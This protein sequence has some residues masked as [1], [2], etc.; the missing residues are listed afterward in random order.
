MTPSAPMPPASRPVD[1]P[2]RCACG[3]L[4][5][6]AL[7][8]G[9]SMGTR[10]LCYC[11]D[12]QAFARFLGGPGILDH[13]GGTD[14]FQIA[15]ARV[16][17]SEAGALSCMRLSA[18]GMFRFYCGQCRTPVGN[19]VGPR[20]PL[21]SLHLPFLE[22]DGNVTLRDEWLGPPLGAVQTKF[23]VGELPA[24]NAH[25]VRVVAKV[26]SRLGT[27]WLTGAGSPSPFFDAKTRAPRVEPRV[28]S[29]QERADLRA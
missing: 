27:W 10:M 24:R 17:L 29:A 22:P 11:D 9:P 5:G 3:A 19:C 25:A 18:K 13:W 16:R 14:V 6:E 23:A 21:I 26:L 2:L 20:L 7:S 8:V 15:P 28:L 4:R 1:R 12:C